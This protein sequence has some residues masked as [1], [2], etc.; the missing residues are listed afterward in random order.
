MLFALIFFWSCKK[1]FKNGDDTVF[2][3]KV[4]ILGHAGMGQTYYM[5]SNTYE[6]VSAAISVGCDGSEIDIQMTRDSVLVAFHDDNLSMVTDGNGKIISRDWAYVSNCRYKLAIEPVYVNSLDELLGKIHNRKELYFSLDMKLAT[7]QPDQEAYEY[8]VMR[9]IKRICEK[10]DM[11]DMIFIE[12]PASF[13]DKAKELG[14]QNMLFL[15]TD[16]VADPAGMAKE[17]YDGILHYMDITDEQ[18]EDAHKSGLFVM[19]YNPVNAAENDD[20][21]GKRPDI[22]QTDD[23]RSILKALNRYDYEDAVP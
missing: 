13:L 14:M 2:G 9:A 22:I 8:C 11:E 3:S 20:V 19:L 15:F 16:H 18:M 12:G 17:K 1:E 6:S 5:P 21:L 4:M 10:Y 23:P 7:G